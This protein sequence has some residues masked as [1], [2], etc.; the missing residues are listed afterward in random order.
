VRDEE[1]ERMLAKL[2]QEF[3]D[4]TSLGIA[5]VGLDGYPVFVNRRLCRILGYS[6]EELVRM[7]FSDLC[8]PD[9]KEMDR[10]LFQGLVEGRGE[11][12]SVRRRYI[13]KDGDIVTAHVDGGIIRDESGTPLFMIYTIQDISDQVAAE[14]DALKRLRRLEA[15][16]EIDRAI[17]RHLN[18]LEIM[19]IILE[20]VPRE[21]GADAVA[22]SVLEEEGKGFKHFVMRFPDGLVIHEQAFD[23]A[24][25]LMF[26]LVDM[27]ELVVIPNIGADPRLR[28]YA[29]KVHGW[30]LVSYVGVP[31]VVR[32]R[33]I[34]VLHMFT[35]RPR[36]FSPEDLAFFQILAGQAAI[37]V[38]NARMFYEISERAAK[39][40]QFL[41]MQ[42]HL[43]LTSP[44]QIPNT[45]LTALKDVL[46]VEHA[47]Y[48]DYEE[49]SQSLYLR[50]SIGF[51]E[52]RLPSALADPRG[53]IKLGEGA[54][55]IAAK[56]RRAIYIPDTSS[57]PLWEGFAYDSEK[58]LRSVYIL[59][60]AFGDR[61]F[62]VVVVSSFEPNAFD[63][64]QRSLM[65]NFVAYAS[66]AMEVAKLLLEADRRARQLEVL[67]RISQAANRRLD[68]REI[69][70]VAI[71]GLLEIFPDI[72]V[73]I[74][75]YDPPLDA[76]RLEG[77]NERGKSF[78]DIM[79]LSIGDLLAIG[80]DGVLPLGIRIGVSAE[81]DDLRKE[82]S[83]GA[84]DLV[85]A[86]IISLME[87]PV[88]SGEELLGFI[89]LGSAFPNGFISEEQGFFSSF[90]D[91]LALAF[92]NVMLFSDLQKANEELRQA[93]DMMMR[94]ERLRALGQMASGIVHDINNALTPIVGYAELL[95]EHEDPQ[96]REKVRWIME[97][98]GDIARIVKGMRAFYRPRSP[99]E[100]MVPLDLNELVKEAVEMTRPRWYTTS[101]QRGIKIDLV[102]RLDETLPLITGIESEVREALMN[103]IFNSV[104][105]ILLKGEPSGTITITTSRR[106]GWI[107]V[108]V[109]D[110][111]T[112]MDEETCRRA[113]EP[114]FTRK[115]GGS[116]L[117]LA[118]VYGIMQRHEGVAEIESQLGVGTVV[119]L[120][121]PSQ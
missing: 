22:I 75:S 46:K 118:M 62:G 28:I 29:D 104:D 39:L 54:I 85:R 86:G 57:E 115:E 103:L 66:A 49:R 83:E 26:H 81:I 55:G 112:G 32:R 37:A 24:N 44:D 7:R 67:D 117:G 65:D 111:G 120:L 64:F 8:H 20:H 110:T 97:A 91:H 27:K 1:R 43:S 90:A 52:E 41:P 93:Q 11:R 3:L 69:V 94:Q 84:R 109:S 80:K 105:A 113:F 14:L 99:E 9:D 59:P 2:F 35:T 73:A 61:L 33:T 23:L 96:V 70:A 79:G 25:S 53:T 107:S 119:R 45:V 31:L 10:Y 30:R 6:E 60:L 34:G 88:M 106:D 38:E 71:S 18:I 74:W 101:R 16:R 121:F 100:E 102:L 95:A 5:I 82:E 12:Y 76:F 36:S 98:A 87:I 92:K 15:L 17:I 50:T 51:P 56:E 63:S 40:E 78:A 108:E 47:D 89:L 4:H 42:A 58:P 13:H 21:L 77:Y 48:Y 116:G 72:A 114:F 68:V 19:E